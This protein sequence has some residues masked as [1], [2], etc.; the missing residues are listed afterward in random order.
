MSEHS[1]FVGGRT[2]DNLMHQLTVDMANATSP[3]VL[4]PLLHLYL[5]HVFDLVLQKH[6]DKSPSVI[7]ERSSYLQ[8]L[9]I[10]YAR[11]LISDERYENLKAI[12]NI[13]NNFAHSFDP[14]DTTIEN[15]ATRLS[16]HMYTTARPWLDRYSASVID[17]MSILAAMID[18]DQP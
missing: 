10:L 15:Q 4:V 16:G 13:R 6:W 14:N 9:Q 1:G 12:N 2:G 5:D 17:S 11:N 3:R 8:K 18:R 7:N